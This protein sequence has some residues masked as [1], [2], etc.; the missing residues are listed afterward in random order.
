MYLLNT[1]VCRILV[2]NF[3][4]LFF[5]RICLEKAT[6]TLLVMSTFI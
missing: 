2:I 4:S 5:N 1:F 3:S 6:E